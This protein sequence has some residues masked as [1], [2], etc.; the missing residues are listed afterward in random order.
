MMPFIKKFI[1]CGFLI[2]LLA[3]SNGQTLKKTIQTP[4]LSK[5]G[6]MILAKNGEKYG[7]FTTYT[8]LTI[9][10]NQKSIYVD[11]SREYEFSDTLYPL[12]FKISDSHFELLV[13]VN[14]RPNKNYLSLL[15]IQNDKVIKI[16][17]LPTFLCKGKKLAQDNSII[18]A[19]QWDYGE[20]WTDENNELQTVYNP[21]IFYKVTDL[22]ISLDTS[23]TIERNKLIYGKF[24]G[25]RYSEK[26][27]IKVKDLGSK[28]MTEIGRIEDY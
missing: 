4:K 5:Y 21:I 6:F 28:L 16:D 9:K 18:Y 23:L 15:H 22:G 8:S 7:D 10:H 24:K 2:L 1:N 26:T 19:G 27:P 3:H 12:I 25:F 20:E 11:T 14:D 13:E 17:T